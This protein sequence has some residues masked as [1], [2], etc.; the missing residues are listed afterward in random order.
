MRVAPAGNHLARHARLRAALADADLSALLITSLPNISYLTGLFASAASLIVGPDELRLII[1]G[2]Y[3][4]AAQDRQRDLPGLALVLV[5]PSGSFEESIAAELGALGARTGFEAAHVTVR[6]H[7]DIV[8]RLPKADREL[9]LCATEGLVEGLRSVKD[10]WELGRLREGAERL[11]DAAKCILPKVLAGRSERGLAEIIVAELRRAG[12][13]KPAFDTIVASGPHSALPHH[14][15]GDRLLADGDLVVLDFGGTLDGYS[16]DLSRTV[17]VGKPGVRERELF[18]HVAEAQESAYLAIRPGTSAETVDEI[19]RCVLEGAG[20]G[21]AFCH[22]TGH[23]L[24]LEVHE[25]PR[26]G[27]RRADRADEVLQAGM[28]FT[29]EPGAYLAGWGGVRIEDDV[30]VTEDKAEWL[31]D[32]P[33]HL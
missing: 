28:V 30:V 9:D 13:D 24:G 33:R 20:L 16:V 22:G 1:D 4:G 7:R 2:R 15:A 6:Q 10:A 27:R 25:R 14:R 3:R 11:S 21:E 17:A 5:P 26:L 19:A 23:G 32:V 31:T 29:L 8:R 18:D 12:F